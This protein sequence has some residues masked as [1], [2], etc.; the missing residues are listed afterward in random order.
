M[1]SGTHLSSASSVDELDDSVLSRLRE[2]RQMAIRVASLASST[3]TSP[4]NVSDKKEINFLFPNW[5]I[6]ASTGTAF[7]T[8]VLSA[9]LFWMQPQF[10]HQIN[11]QVHDN[12]V[13]DDINLLNQ[14]ENLE[15]YQN[16]E[17]YLWLE[18]ETTS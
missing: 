17:F 8:I 15:F 11:M 2:S 4:V 1:G 6:P 5:L 16:L 14:S 12:T 7:A 13:E 9:T 3:K 18:N 10:H